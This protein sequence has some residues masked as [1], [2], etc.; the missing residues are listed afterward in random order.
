MR[1]GD[2]ATGVHEGWPLVRWPTI[3]QRRLNQSRLK[4]ENPKVYE[5]FHDLTSY[6]R[7]TIAGER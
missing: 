1:L 4:L 6:R 2:A 3:E 5:E 7:F